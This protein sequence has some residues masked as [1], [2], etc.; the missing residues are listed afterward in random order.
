MPISQLEPGEIRGTVR[1]I[2]NKS[3]TEEEKEIAKRRAKT[4]LTP[5]L[6]R[7]LAAGRTPLSAMEN[8]ACQTEIADAVRNIPGV[9]EV[10]VRP[11]LS[12]QPISVH[13]KLTVNM[14]TGEVEIETESVT[15]TSPKGPDFSESDD[16]IRVFR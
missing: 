12:G 8:N 6:D 2:L 9:E 10:Q 4:A 5:I 16:V 11:L 3:L 15:N 14:D 1:I 7:I 13:M